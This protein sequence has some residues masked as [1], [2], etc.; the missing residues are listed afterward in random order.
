M[1]KTLDKKW[2]GAYNIFKIMN[3]SKTQLLSSTEEISKLFRNL[4]K[5]SHLKILLAIG[6]GEACVCHLEAAT[7]WRQAYISQQLMVLRSEGLVV[8]RRE[9]RNIY[10]RLNN[11]DILDLIYKA[12]GINGALDVETAQGW[13]SEPLPNCTCPHCTSR[14]PHLHPRKALTLVIERS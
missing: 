4:G 6:S 8:S 9:G 12:G 10:Y 14:E 11:T 5:P 1:P 13:L 7:G 3:I 2:P